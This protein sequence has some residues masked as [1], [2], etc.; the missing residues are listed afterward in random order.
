[1]SP[2]FPKLHG[3]FRFNNQA[4]NSINKSFHYPTQS[5]AWPDYFPCP[6]IPWPNSQCSTRLSSSSMANGIPDP[7]QCYYASFDSSIPS[8][9]STFRICASVNKGHWRDSTGRNS[10]GLRCRSRTRI[11]T[12]GRVFNS[13]SGCTKKRQCIDCFTG[14]MI[15]RTSSSGPAND[16]K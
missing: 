9:A 2:L 10:I 3:T 14:R 15:V 13:P 16:G 5:L 1:M 12:P 7:P 4:K 6:A 8:L 11:T